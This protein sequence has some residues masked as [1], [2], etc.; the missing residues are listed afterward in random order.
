MSY[1]TFRVLLY[2]VVTFL[3]SLIQVVGPYLE[4]DTWPSLPRTI[5]ALLTALI[6]TASTIRAYYDGSALRTQ[7]EAAQTVPIQIQKP[8]NEQHAT[9]P[10]KD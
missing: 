10:T 5:L 4:K 1:T 3:A 8:N 9:A 2:S 7:Q 6:G